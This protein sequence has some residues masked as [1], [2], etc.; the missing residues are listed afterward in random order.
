[1]GCVPESGL[2]RYGSHAP[3][4]AEHLLLRT[5]RLARAGY[6]ALSLPLHGRR[7]IYAGASGGKASPFRSRAKEMTKELDPLWPATAGSSAERARHWRL[8]RVPFEAE[9][10]LPSGRR[11]ASDNYA[12]DAAR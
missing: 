5:G 7:S 8:D 2:T 12:D 11:S 9:P 4:D 1:V 10:E 3:R 6:G